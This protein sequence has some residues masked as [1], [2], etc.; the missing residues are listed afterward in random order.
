MFVRVRHFN[1]N[2]LVMDKRITAG[3]WV[4]Q[5]REWRLNGSSMG[6]EHWRKAV[7]AATASS[8]NLYEF[9]QTRQKVCDLIPSASVLHPKDRVH[10]GGT[11]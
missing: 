6:L 3:L 5:G 10:H 11:T 1:H 7:W 4:G 8:L 2:P 9:N